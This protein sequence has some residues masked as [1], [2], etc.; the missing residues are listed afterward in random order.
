[1]AWRRPSYGRPKDRNVAL[2]W[3]IIQDQKELQP[4]ADPVE[5]DEAGGGSDVELAEAQGSRRK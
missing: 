3:W 1:M 4:T 5:L 2:S